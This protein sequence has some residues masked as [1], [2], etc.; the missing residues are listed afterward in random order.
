ME[1]FDWKPNGFSPIPLYKQIEEYI[2]E[3]I[4]NGEW[5]IG[6]KLPSQRAFS[7]AFEVNRSTIIMALDELA[8]Q[9]L[10][11]GKGRR[12]TIVRN[13]TWSVSTLVPPPNWNSYVETGIYYP[14]L[15]TIQEINEAEFY[16]HIIRLGTGE[17]APELLPEKKTKQIMKELSRGKIPLGYEEPR[18]DFKLREQI[19]TYLQK[20]DIFASPASILIVSGAIQALQLISMGLLCKG[21]SI[22]LEKPSYL[23]SLN[24][25]Q[26]AGMRLFGIPMDENGVQ[27]SLISK[28]KRRF[29][30]SILYTIPSFH[31]PTSLVMNEQRRQDVMKV[32][33]EI[34]LPIIEDAVYQ[35]LWLDSSPPKPLKAY[36]TNGIVLHIGSMSKVIS[37]GLRIGWVVGPEPVIKRLADIKMQMDYGSSSLSQRVAAEWFASELYEK[38]IQQ[39][40]IELK[41]R[42]DFMLAMLEKYCRDI[43]TWQIPSGG[44]YIWLHIEQNISMRELFEKA[45]QEKILL[46]PGNVY[47][48]NASQ[49]LRLSYSYASMHDI[50]KG[51]EMVARL[52]KNLSV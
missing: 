45:L 27:P 29:N 34:G 28:Y 33:N 42:R 41:K 1:R 4:I 11:E 50:E 21:S 5:T 36:D 24:V 25:F 16:P 9:G 46:N 3:K 49:Y 14:N 13:D 31:N 39:I 20:Y 35:D 52:I 26:S 51:I 15:P 37:P 17:L 22:L 43:A 10:I 8:A 12:G 48:R 30:G 47:D 18:G 44:F 40:R 2:K 32:C 7:Q 19:A 23:Y 6:T 38:H